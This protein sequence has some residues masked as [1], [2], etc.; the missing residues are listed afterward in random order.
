MKGG[1]IVILWYSGFLFIAATGLTGLQELSSKSILMYIAFLFCFLLG[2]VLSGVSLYEPKKEMHQQILKRKHNLVIVSIFYLF[3]IYCFL[4]ALNIYFFNKVDLSSYRQAFFDGSRDNVKFFFGSFGFYFYYFLSLII[5]AL[6]PFVVIMNN[7]KVLFLCFL[8]LLLYDIIFLSRTGV[9][10]YILSYIVA[11]IIQKKQLKKIIIFIV[12]A[13]LFSFVISYARD[14]QSNIINSI[15]SSIIN[16]HVAPFILLDNNII[17]K[18][19]I[20]YHGVGL[21]SLGIYNIIFFPIDVTI[22]QTINDFRTQ[23]NMFYDL[24][25]KEY[26][27]Y[28]AYYTSLGGVYIDSGFLGCMIVTFFFGFII[29]AIEKKAYK[30]RK[31]LASTVFFTTLC[32]ESIFAP[33]TLNIFSFTII[34]YLIIALVLKYENCNGSP[35][36][37]KYGS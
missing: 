31:Y 33:I 15:F 28:N 19:V 8:S 17:S 9:Y 12:I 27:P 21:A 16:Y 29:V 18:N 37:K 7:K 36:F 5:Y 13:L 11:Y 4:V 6:V 1:L 3:I 35:V 14:M 22:M 25:L 2:M 24:G 10:Y 26:L 23:L 20:T 34:I 30:S 32:L